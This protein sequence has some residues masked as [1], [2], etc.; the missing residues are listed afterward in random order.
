ME[1]TS[2]SPAPRGS[3]EFG[4]REP[5]L[6]IPTPAT[7]DR[8][9][10]EQLPKRLIQAISSSL[11]FVRDLNTNTLRNPRFE[12]RMPRVRIKIRDLRAA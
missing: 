8:S 4:S 5:G 7:S 3:P 11:H 6:A 1:V 9:A 12:Y 2:D 10:L